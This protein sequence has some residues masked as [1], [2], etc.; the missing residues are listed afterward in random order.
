[1]LSEPRDQAEAKCAELAQAI[2]QQADDDQLEALILGIGVLHDQRT[3]ETLVAIQGHPGATVRRAVA[4]ALPMAM[5]VAERSSAGVAALISLCADDNPEVR[6]WATC[7]LG[8]T[9]AAYR[10]D[11][12]DFYV[13]AE[14]HATS[15]GRHFYTD[16]A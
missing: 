3:L 1:M 14:S 15:T 4:K 2:E 13:T 6:D 11:L 8:R 12:A 10:S 7:S 16:T 9:L 5:V